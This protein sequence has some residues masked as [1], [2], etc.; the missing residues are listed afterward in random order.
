MT[1]ANTAGRY[2]PRPLN[3]KQQ[4][5]LAYLKT[6]NPMPTRMQ[7]CKKFGWKNHS[8]AQQ[9]LERLEDHQLITLENRTIRVVDHE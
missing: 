2:G 9:A 4:A 6:C 3:D 1:T 5:L 8:Q 7:L